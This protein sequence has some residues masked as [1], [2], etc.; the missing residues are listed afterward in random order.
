MI[1]TRVGRA[2]AVLVFVPAIASAVSDNVPAE[3][4]KRSYTARPVNSSSVARLP[5]SSVTFA[6]DRAVTDSLSVVLASYDNA[7]VP[8]TT[9]NQANTVNQSTGSILFCGRI[10][11]QGTPAAY[12][13]QQNSSG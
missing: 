1:A 6:L 13:T 5:A 12:I 11:V 4:V 10:D 9:T 3:M 8:G 7:G 2:L